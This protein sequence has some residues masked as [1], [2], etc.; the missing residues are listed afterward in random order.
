MINL[1]VLPTLD[2]STEAAIERLEAWST[3]SER[4]RIAGRH[5]LRSST[6]GDQRILFDLLDVSA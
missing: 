3:L 4:R 1:T 5:W 6:L 2:G